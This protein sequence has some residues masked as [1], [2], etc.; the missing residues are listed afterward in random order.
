MNFKDEFKFVV[1]RVL[2]TVIRVLPTMLIHVKET[3]T[4]NLLEDKLIDAD[5]VNSF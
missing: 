5:I 3:L 4:M 2:N 1:L